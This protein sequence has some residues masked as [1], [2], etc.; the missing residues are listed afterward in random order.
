M[1][2]GVVELAGPAGAGKTTVARALV[3]ALPGARLGPTPGRLATVRSVVTTAPVLLATRSVAAPGR[4]WSE[5]ELRSVGYLLAWQHQLRNAVAGEPLLLDHG[6]VFRLAM[7]V[8]GRPQALRHPVFG[9]WWWRTATAWAGLLDAV[10]VLDAPTE[11]L[12]ARIEARPREHRVRGADP[13]EAERF[14]D[15]YRVAFDEV[16]RVVSGEGTPVVRVDAAGPPE[17][18]ADDVRARLLVDTSGDRR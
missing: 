13:C 2:V 5:A 6:P 16:L 8:A 7:L 15:A 12:I 3:R 18:V 9:P 11:E 14:I 1:T 10:V 4:W 17:A